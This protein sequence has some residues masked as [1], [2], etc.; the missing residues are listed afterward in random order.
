MLF[1]ILCTFS[2][3]EQAQIEQLF[4]ENHALLYK[5]SY[6][7]LRS[8]TDAEDAVA[9]AFLNIMEHFEKISRLSRPVR[10]PYC[11]VIAKNT[12]Y[13]ILR[14]KK[15][16][17]PV[18]EFYGDETDDDVVDTFFEKFEKTQLIAALKLLDENDRTLLTFRFGRD[19]SLKDIAVLME[20]SEET[21]KKRSQ[22]A[23]KKL[24]KILGEFER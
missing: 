13:D 15:R 19:M 8:E 14:R 12:S 3:D 7:L 18:E 22:R 9:Q 21:A 4:K 6:Q 23:L 17:I 20:I 24:K 2:E 11:G 1:L 16:L 10:R 5:V